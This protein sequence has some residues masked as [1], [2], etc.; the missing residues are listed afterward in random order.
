[1]SYEQ[2]RLGPQLSQGGDG[3]AEARFVE[4]IALVTRQ[5]A[6]L[7]DFALQRTPWDLLVTY[8]PFPDEALH[9]WYGVLDPTLAGHDPEVARRLHPYLDRVLA[10]IDAYVGQVV[11]RAGPDAIV[12][13]ASDHGMTSDNRYF[14]P[15]VVLARAGLLAF[16]A[17]GR[18]DLSR[19]QAVYFPGNSGYVVINRQGRPGGIVPPAA[20]EDVRRRVTAA[21]TAFKDPATGRTLGV[22]VTDVRAPQSGSKLGLNAGDLYVEVS[23]GGVALSARATGDAL[24]ARR[25]EG[26]H[27]QKPGERRLQGSFVIAGPGVMA[28]ADLGVIEQVDI[29]PTLAALLG[30]DPLAHAVGKP[31]TAAMAN[32]P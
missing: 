22:T 18:V 21:L 12:A 4:T 9:R 10:L 30:M 31:L 14:K 19:T 13:V 3:T 8:L 24:E 6:R 2:G 26:T 7:D 23:A 32:K 29:A 28:G 11:D 15:N 27:F 1:L 5:F 20:E 25:P 17:A 16:D